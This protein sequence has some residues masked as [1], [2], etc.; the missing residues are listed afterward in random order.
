MLLIGLEVVV[1][2]LF[3]QKWPLVQE[4]I[5]TLRKQKIVTR[6]MKIN[7]RSVSCILYHDLGVR[8]YK[9]MYKP[10]ES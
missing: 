10:S 3:K 1:L 6:K 7:A 2:V 4:L 9:K 8:V 5:V